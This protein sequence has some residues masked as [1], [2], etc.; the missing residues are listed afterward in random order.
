MS[1]RRFGTLYRRTILAGAYRPARRASEGI[2]QEPSLARR[3]GVGRVSKNPLTLFVLHPPNLQ[4]ARINL[5]GQNLHAQIKRES[6][7]SGAPH[8]D[9]A[10]TSWRIVWMPCESAG[11]TSEILR[12]IRSPTLLAT[13]GTRSLV[14]QPIK[15]FLFVR[16]Q[17]V[18]HGGS[19]SA[20]SP[21][22]RTSLAFDP[23]HLSL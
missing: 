3:A 23:P 16:A 22:M 9:F 15:F 14:H 1:N 13:P 20:A 19:H 21:V 5:R 10:R 18:F 8:S 6:P 17:G 2:I 4:T 11:S 7:Y 12:T